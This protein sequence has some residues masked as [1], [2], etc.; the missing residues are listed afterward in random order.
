MHQSNVLRT[1]IKIVMIIVFM[2]VR[3]EFFSNRSNEESYIIPKYFKYTDLFF[4]LYLDIAQWPFCYFHG[5]HSNE[6]G[7][8]SCSLYPKK[9]D[10]IPFLGFV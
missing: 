9:F 6:F 10:P 4:K 1:F 7:Q 3:N 5:S 8:S 2:I